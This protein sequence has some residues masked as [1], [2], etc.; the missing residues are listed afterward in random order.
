[1]SQETHTTSG[2]DHSTPFMLED[3]LYDENRG[4]DIQTRLK[5]G[6]MLDYG[7]DLASKKSQD[8]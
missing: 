3:K 8:Q 4:Q 7:P 1:M 5:H 6:T 2:Q